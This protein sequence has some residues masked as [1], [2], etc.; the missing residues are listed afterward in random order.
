MQK[1]WNCWFSA[2]TAVPPLAHWVHIGRFCA[3]LLIEYIFCP[4]PHA[5]KILI[6]CVLFWMGTLLMSA[7]L[8]S[9]LRGAQTCV[10]AI[11]Y[12]GWRR[13]LLNRVCRIQYWCGTRRY[14]HRCRHYMILQDITTCRI[15]QGIYP[16]VFRQLNNNMN[17]CLIS[18]IKCWE[19][20]RPVW[21]SWAGQEISS[22]HI[23]LLVFRTYD[24]N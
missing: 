12:N 7:I 11:E 16:I 5:C 21:S 14:C 24:L 9:W 15:I 13:D 3:Y 6:F 20:W 19:T 10:S 17:I 1:F 23:Y 2:V 8:L 4:R 22:E 18:I